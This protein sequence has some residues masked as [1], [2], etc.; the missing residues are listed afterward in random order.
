MTAL[1]LPGF[2]LLAVPLTGLYVAAALAQE[3]G[4]RATQPYRLHRSRK[5]HHLAAVQAWR[6]I[7]RMVHRSGLPD[8]R[9]SDCAKVLTPA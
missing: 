2:G 1:S 4:P 5:R 6:W 8:P 9:P 3:V 7:G